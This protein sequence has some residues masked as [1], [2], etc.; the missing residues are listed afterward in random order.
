M[1]G[2]P[3]RLLKK[4]QTIQL[5]NKNTDTDF[6]S[7]KADSLNVNHINQ[8]GASQTKSDLEKSA[9]NSRLIDANNIS[10]KGSSDQYPDEQNVQENA[11]KDGNKIISTNDRSRRDLFEKARSCSAVNEYVVPLK[12]DDEPVNDKKIVTVRFLNLMK[13]QFKKLSKDGTYWS[14]RQL[15]SIQDHGYGEWKALCIEKG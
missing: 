11:I 7:N 10:P 13:D 3:A 8:I 4:E 15:K 2:P 14:W 6:I 12:D 9:N 1:I 5:L